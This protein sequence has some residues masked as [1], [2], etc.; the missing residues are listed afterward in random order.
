MNSNAQKGFTLIELTAA[1]LITSLIILA[2]ASSLAAISDSWDRGERLAAARE[3][4]RVLS[5]RLGMELASA[6]QGLLGRETGFE[7]DRKGFSF[8]AAGELG[9]R[10]LTLAVQEGCILLIEKP[11]R[12]AGEQVSKIILADQV[13]HLEIHYYDPTERAWRNE[14]QAKEEGRP[15][16]LVRIRA[17]LGRP[18][19]LYGAP[20]L[21]LPVYAGRTVSDREVD[22]L[23]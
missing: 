23:D 3:A 14:W 15:P 8:T 1:L 20:P 17:Y 13:D 18:E 6:N 2:I 11:L 16:S 7:G 22:P 12:Q 5:R 9:P 21:I 4:V 19:H 10:R